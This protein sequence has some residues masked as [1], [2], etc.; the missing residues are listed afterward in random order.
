MR[1]TKHQPGFTLVELLT[2]LAII[3]L[4]SSL[5]MPSFQQTHQRSQRGLAKLALL[6]SAHWMER[7][8]NSNGAYPVNLP[9][10]VWHSPDIRYR[11][12]M[13]SSGSS[14][15]LQATPVGGQT[16]DACGSLTLSATGE[17]GVQNAALTAN[18]CWGT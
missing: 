14:F 4:L 12:S 6:K 7:S 17:R 3:G 2:V 13:T 11:L 10:A 15:V 1:H 9:D 16:A 5:A 18:T 8:F